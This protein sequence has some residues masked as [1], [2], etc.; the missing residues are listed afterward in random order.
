MTESGE[1]EQNVAVR[2]RERLGVPM[3]TGD[4]NRLMDRIEGTYKDGVLETQIPQPAPPEPKK[5][6]VEVKEYLTH[7]DREAL[8]SSLMM[9]LPQ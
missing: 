4:M 2:E 9:N 1:Q 3:R 7:R 8:Q 6:S 5:P